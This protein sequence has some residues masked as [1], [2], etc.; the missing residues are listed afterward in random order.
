MATP[1]P[2]R[3]LKTKKGK[4]KKI[5]IK[6]HVKIKKKKFLVVKKIF[7]NYQLSIM[8]KCEILCKLIK[9]RLKK[10]FNFQ[11]LKTFYYYYNIQS[12]K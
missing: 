1:P 7:F 12:K 8:K 11:N 5:K 6:S 10:I 9:I 4:L 2:F 3:S